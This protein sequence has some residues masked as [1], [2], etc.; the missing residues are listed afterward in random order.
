MYQWVRIIP[1][2]TSCYQYVRQATGSVSDT[3]SLIPDPAFSVKYGIVP[4][5]S[6]L[7]EKFY[8]KLLL[9]YP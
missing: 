4:I 6:K 7:K 9:T 8:H 2:P 5:G 3:D 1:F